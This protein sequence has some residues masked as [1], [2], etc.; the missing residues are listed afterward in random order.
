MA[1]DVVTYYVQNKGNL[2]YVNLC[3]RYR[4]T[5]KLI[6]SNIYLDWGLNLLHFVL[7]IV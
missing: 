6:Q 2:S 3:T 7:F 4:N 5:V 1:Y